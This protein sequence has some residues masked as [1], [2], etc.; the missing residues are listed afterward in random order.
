M[1]G[2]FT[3]D[4]TKVGQTIDPGPCVL[5]SMKLVSAPSG[6]LPPYSYDP[7]SGIPTGNRTMC[8]CTHVGGKL[9]QFYNLPIWD[10]STMIPGV[11]VPIVPQ[12]PPATPLTD[13]VLT[14]MPPGCQVEITTV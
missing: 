6:P 2:T 4:S 7:V 1:S 9:T 5:Q 3:L 13:L 8:L 10:V 11:V 12:P 14:A